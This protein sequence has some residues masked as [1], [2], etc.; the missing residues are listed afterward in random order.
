[1]HIGIC[2]HGRHGKDTVAEY[3]ARITPL[4]YVAGTSW[5]AAPLVYQRFQEMGISYPSVTACWDDRHNHRQ[6]WSDTIGA[7]NT[8]DPVRLYRDCLAEQDLLTGLRWRHELAEVKAA[9]LCDL[10]LWVHDP[11]KPLDPTCQIAEADCDLTIF[12]GGTLAELHARLDKLGL[13][14]CDHVARRSAA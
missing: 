6:L 1:M 12:N 14:L 5:W 11:R 3:L 4:R 9:K 2:G 7:I 8:P 13:M 10:W